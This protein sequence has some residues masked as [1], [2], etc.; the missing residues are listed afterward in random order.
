M[1]EN[2]EVQQKI[3]AD[4]ER[5]AKEAGLKGFEK[6]RAIGLH[7]EPFS[8]ESGLLTASFKSKRPQLRSF[9]RPQIDVMY[10]RLGKGE[11]NVTM[12]IPPGN[13]GESKVFTKV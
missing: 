5:L 11:R 10:A 1:C 2:A 3:M 6:A 12:A 13:P 4:M 8:V 9:Y 7:A